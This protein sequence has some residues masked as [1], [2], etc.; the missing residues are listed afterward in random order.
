MPDVQVSPVRFE[1]HRAALGIGEHAPRLSWHIVS[2]PDG[3]HQAGYE[4]EIGS[5]RSRVDSPESVLVPWPAT[6][7]R[8]RDRRLVRVRMTGADGQASGWS[9][10]AAV[11]AGLLRPGDWT[12]AMISP[13]AGPAPLV[14]KPFRL[15]APVARARL[16]VTAHGLYRAE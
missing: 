4:V 9:P 11:E 1:H 8:S 5:E 14:R 15:D 10:P 6:A 2:A 13:A 7:L 16:Y 12:A 3:W